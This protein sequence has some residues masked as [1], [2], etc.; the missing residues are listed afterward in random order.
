MSIDL[1]GIAVA[2]IAVAVVVLGIVVR[3][4]MLDARA[5]ATLGN[6][7]RNSL[8]AIQQARDA[9]MKDWHAVQAVTIPDVPESLVP[10]VQYVLDHAGKEAAR[11]RIGPAAIADKIWAQMGLAAIAAGPKPAPGWVDPTN[12]LLGQRSAA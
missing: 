11:F 4:L 1:T 8:G 6:A 3:S 12:R 2:V 5:A 7:V 10:G 9:A